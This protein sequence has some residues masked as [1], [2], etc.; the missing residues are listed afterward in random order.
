MSEVPTP[1]ELLQDARRTA[2]HL[3]MR[4]GYTRSDP[5]YQAWACGDS[6][7]FERR[8]ERP[9]LDLIRGV[10]GRGLTGAAR[11]HREAVRVS[12]RRGVGTW[13]RPRGVPGL[14]CPPRPASRR[15]RRHSAPVSGRAAARPA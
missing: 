10:T 13:H 8:L 9:W 2:S 11:P 4:D 3:E 15:P 12:V 6:A 1:V 5:W 7:E 14:T